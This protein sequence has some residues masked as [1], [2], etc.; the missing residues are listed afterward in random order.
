MEW[1]V[2][3][4]EQVQQATMTARERVRTTLDHRQPDRIPIDFGGTPVT[5]I[6]VSVVA[7]LRDHYGLEPRLVKVHEPYQMLGIVDDDLKEA[8]GIDVEGVVGR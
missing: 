5:G 7:G 3:M 6:H 2:R 8:M 1:G 4:T